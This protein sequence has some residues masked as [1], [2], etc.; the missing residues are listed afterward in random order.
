MENRYLYGQRNRKYLKPDKKT[1]KECKTS[2]NIGTT[3]TRWKDLMTE[4]ILSS[5]GQVASFLLDK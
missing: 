1:N 5:D 2:V 4:K 3:Y